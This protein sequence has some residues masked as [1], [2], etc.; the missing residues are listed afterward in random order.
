MP[1]F[2]PRKKRVAVYFNNGEYTFSMWASADGTKGPGR[3]NLIAAVNAG[4]A[5]FNAAYLKKSKPQ[6]SIAPSDDGMSKASPPG[7]H[8]DNGAQDRNSTEKGRLA[9]ARGETE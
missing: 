5:A 4:R 9:K 1:E 3:A 8:A 2:R 7:E 6:D